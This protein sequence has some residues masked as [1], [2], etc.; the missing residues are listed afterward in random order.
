M[1]NVDGSMKEKNEH[2][3]QLVYLNNMMIDYFDGF[4]ANEIKGFEKISVLKNVNWQM[5]IG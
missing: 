4:F 1:Y 5:R 2:N 3:V